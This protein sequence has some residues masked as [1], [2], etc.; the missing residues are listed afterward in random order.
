MRK[1][2]SLAEVDQAM[3]IGDRICENVC[4]TGAIRV[5]KKKAVVDESKCGAC[6]KCVDYCEEGAIRMVPRS[7]PLF[8]RVDPSDVDQ[9]Q[10]RGLCTKAHVH[11]DD[12]ICPC[13]GTTAGEVGA[14]ILKGATTPEEVSL[15]TG[16]RTVCG[17]YCV[18]LVQELLRAH[19]IETTPPKGA[20]WYEVDT[21]LWNIPEEVIRKYPEYRLEES[22]RLFLENEE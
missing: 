4:P 1:V 6:L 5:V 7:Q 17:I 16:V 3:C 22:R 9:D 2:H 19:G 18:S 15:M 20:N 8:W 10:L 21:S 13:T 11:L 12:V 14:A